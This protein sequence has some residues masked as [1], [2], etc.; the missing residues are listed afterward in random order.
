MITVIKRNGQRQP[1][2]ENKIRISLEATSD[3]INQPMSSGEISN[4]VKEVIEIFKGKSEITARQI[5]LVIAGIL[6][7]DG[8]RGVLSAYTDFKENAWK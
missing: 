5:Y 7:A 6:Y 8:Y 1:F 2:D 3:E 4:V